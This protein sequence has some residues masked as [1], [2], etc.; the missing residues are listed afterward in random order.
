MNVKRCSLTTLALLT[1]SLALSACAPTGGGLFC[2]V[3]GGPLEFEAETAQAIVRTDRPAAEQ[4]DA[5]NAYGRAN[6]DW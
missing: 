1:G 3:V 4:I 6:C 5:Q 2:D